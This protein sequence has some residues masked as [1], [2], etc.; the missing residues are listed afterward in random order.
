MKRCG[1]CGQEKPIVEFSKLAKAYDGLQGYCKSCAKLIDKAY[2]ERNRERLNAAHRARAGSNRD[3]RRT[4]SRE[5]SKNNLPLVAQQAAKRRASIRYACPKWANRFFIAE[6]YRLAE[7]R[8]EVTG[9]E[10]HVD[11]IVPLT[12]PIVCGL[13]CEHNLQVIP[14]TANLS[15]HNR[16]WPGMPA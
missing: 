1:K 8:R 3:S 13:H 16:L 4:A 6:A 14:A 10:W 12:S 7:L 11:H 9:V 5:W 15:K 2:R